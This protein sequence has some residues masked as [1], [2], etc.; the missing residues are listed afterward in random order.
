MDTIKSISEDLNNIALLVNKIFIGLPLFFMGI[1]SA[2]SKQIF[3]RL[4]IFM[5]FYLAVWFTLLLISDASIFR[6]VLKIAIESSFAGLII[7]QLS[8]LLIDRM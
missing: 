8:R 3:W 6:E 7:G 5:F 1:A 4:L 2:F